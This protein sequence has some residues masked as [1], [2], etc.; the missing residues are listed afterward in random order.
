[1]NGTG[2]HLRIGLLRAGIFLLALATV[3]T[4]LYYVLSDEEIAP[5]FRLPFVDNFL[6][7]VILSPPCTY[8]SPRWGGFALRRAR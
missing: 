7:Y 3:G 2:T 6:A 4:Y 1:M 5:L 8:S